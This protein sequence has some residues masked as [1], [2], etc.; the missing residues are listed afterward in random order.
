MKSRK[1]Y[2]RIDFKRYQNMGQFLNLP[3]TFY[4]KVFV[5]KFSLFHSQ[6][7]SHMSRLFLSLTILSNTSYHYSVAYHTDFR[8]EFIK[9]NSIVSSKSKF[10]SNIKPEYFSK[11]PFNSKH[12]KCNHET[13]CENCSVAFCGCFRRKLHSNRQLTFSRRRSTSKHRGLS[14]LPSASWHAER[15]TDWL[16]LWRF[17]YPQTLRIVSCTL[18]ALKHTSWINSTLWRINFETDWRQEVLC[19]S[20][21]SPSKLLEIFFGSRYRGHSTSCKF[22]GLRKLV[23]KLD[24]RYLRGSFE[25][26][27]QLTTIQTRTLCSFYVVK[28]KWKSRDKLVHILKDNSVS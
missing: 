12:S 18:L 15:R 6:I 27:I 17:K 2:P 28:V 4:Q 11:K 7:I 9:F 10:R 14:F 25:S 22:E 21:H 5:A 16:H 24:L 13:K 19:V 23:F 26:E 20:I 8:L 3:N 1:D